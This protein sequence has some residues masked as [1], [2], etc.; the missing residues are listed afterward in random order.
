MSGKATYHT[1]VARSIEHVVPTKQ[2]SSKDIAKH[3]VL[4]YRK[5][6][7]N[8]PEEVSGKFSRERENKM[9]EN[10]NDNDV[11]E[12]VREFLDFEPAVSIKEE[13]TEDLANISLYCFDFMK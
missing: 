6:G 7:Q 4:K 5:I 1:K 2:Y 9:K 3:T 8:A 12:K 13:S 10:D 11:K